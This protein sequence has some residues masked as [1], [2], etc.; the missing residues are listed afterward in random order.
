MSVQSY[1]TFVMADTELSHLVQW[2]STETQYLQ[3]PNVVMD[4]RAG[5]Q[6]KQFTVKSFSADTHK[7]REEI[8]FGV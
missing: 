7:L 8:L 2:Q 3:I 4:C 5:L 1:V 6:I